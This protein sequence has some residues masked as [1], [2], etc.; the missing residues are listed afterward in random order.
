M[1]VDNDTHRGETDAFRPPLHG[2]CDNER[3]QAWAILSGHFMAATAWRLAE[4]SN[5]SQ[6]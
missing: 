2:G 4:Y 5:S 1:I 6:G 3:P